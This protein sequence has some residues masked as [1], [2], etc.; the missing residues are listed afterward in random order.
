MLLIVPE[1]ETETESQNDET[2]E[3]VEEET[4]ENN[5]VFIQQSEN[6]EDFSIEENQVN[7]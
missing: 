6:D 1:L 7:L 2:D 5:E 3:S 4:K